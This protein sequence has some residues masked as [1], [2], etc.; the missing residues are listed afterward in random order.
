MTLTVVDATVRFA[1]RAVLD[2]VTLDVAPGATL[3][4]LGP[5]GSGKTT[6]LRA[7]AGLQPLDAGTMH[8]SGT[9]LR[10]VAPHR[11]GFGLMFQD[12]ALFPNRD[13]AGNVAYGLERQGVPRAAREQRVGDLLAAVGLTGFE[14]RRIDTLSGGEQQRVALARSLAPRPGLLLL[15]EPFGALDRLRREQLVADVAALLRASDTAA[16]VVTHDHDEAF[17][18]ADDVLVLREGRVV[19]RAAPAALWRAPAD[20]WTARFVGHGEAVDATVEGTVARTSWGALPVP[21]GTRPGAAR[22]VLRADALR[23]APDGVLRAT[24]LTRSFRSGATVL[25]VQLGDGPPVAVRGDDRFDA[26]TAGADVRVTVDPAAVL[27]YPAVPP[28]TAVEPVT[29]T[30]ENCAESVTSSVEA[31]GV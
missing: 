9:D 18:L 5:S 23:L 27:V 13:V 19:Q 8:W 10:S 21:S 16:I 7:V 3:A 1:G 30:D 2:R 12:H 28:S 24:V 17:A 20:E 29:W 15:D 26:T 25:R 4:V 14:H 11:R 31:T 22:V 6:L